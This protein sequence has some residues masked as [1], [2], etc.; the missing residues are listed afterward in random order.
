MGLITL[1]FIQSLAQFTNKYINDL[2]LRLI[3]SCI[4]IVKK[5]FCG[6][7]FPFKQGQQLQHLIFFTFETDRFAVKL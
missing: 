3:H 4:K 5:Y 2:E 6:L 7:H 1:D